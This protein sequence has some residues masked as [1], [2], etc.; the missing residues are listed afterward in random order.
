MKIIISVSCLN[1]FH[2]ELWIWSCIFY[3]VKE[4]NYLFC[5]HEYR[6]R[7]NDSYYISIQLLLYKKVDFVE[8]NKQR[9]LSKVLFF[10]NPTML[11][12]YLLET[13]KFSI[14]YNREK[15]VG[16]YFYQFV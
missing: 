2:R 12:V 9:G 13:Q 4:L 1:H 5:S 3:P 16:Q 8:I 7:Y 11:G 14:N 10:T 15:N 6:V